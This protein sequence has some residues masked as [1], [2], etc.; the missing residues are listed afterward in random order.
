MTEHLPAVLVGVVITV[1]GGWLLKIRWVH[2]LR[3]LRFLRDA[4]GKARCKLLKKH[5]WK[6]EILFGG[7]Y[8]PPSYTCPYCGE[9]KEEP[10]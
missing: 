9:K 2:A 10:S 8:L 7:A 1:I 6:Q 5:T 3:A 4:W